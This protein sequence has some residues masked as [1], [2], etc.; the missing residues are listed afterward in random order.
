MAIDNS[1]YN[2]CKTSTTFN[3]QLTD[4]IEH[5]PFT[6]ASV[7]KY[8]ARRKDKGF[9]ELDTEKIISYLNKFIEIAK[10]EVETEQDN[11]KLFYYSCLKNKIKLNKEDSQRIEDLIEKIHRCYSVNINKYNLN[12]LIVVAEDLIKELTNEL[13]EF[14]KDPE[15]FFIKHP[16]IKRPPKESKEVK[17]NF[18]EDLKNELRKDPKKIVLLLSELS[19]ELLLEEQSDTLD[20]E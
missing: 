2:S 19:K 17:S 20:L 14:R 10:L 15:Q 6:L 5:M 11:S 13:E 12:V 18:R 7:L 4:S 9:Y 1:H 3:T 16:E 8:L